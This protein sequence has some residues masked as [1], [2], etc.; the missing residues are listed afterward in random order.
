M[1]EKKKK[2]KKVHIL[3]S[4]EMLHFLQNRKNIQVASAKD[5]H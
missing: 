1:Q 5:T 3:M 2:M 4:V